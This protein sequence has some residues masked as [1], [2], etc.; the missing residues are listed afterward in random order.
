MIF[1]VCILKLIFSLVLTK[2]TFINARKYFG[3]IIHSG[4]NLI[5]NS[6]ILI[7]ASL[8]FYIFKSWYIYRIL[9]RQLQFDNKL[10]GSLYHFRLDF[11]F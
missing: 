9:F 8:L 2:N 3:K 5:R 4:V 11:Y 10:N 7:F 6:N 1:K